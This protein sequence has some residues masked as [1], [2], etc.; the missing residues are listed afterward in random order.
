MTS[1]TVDVAGSDA[2]RVASAAGVHVRN[3]HG[4]AELTEAV[5][6]LCSIW[7]F[8][9]GSVV[10]AELLR[11]VAFAGGYVAAAYADGQVVGASAGF[12]GRHPGDLGWHLHSHISGVV[13]AWQGRH[14]GLA[15]KQHQRAWALAAGVTTIEWTFD[16]LVRRNAFF[17]LVKLGADVVGFEASF[18][19]EM[20]DA[21][22][23]GDESDRAVV[24]WDLTSAAAVSAARGFLDRDQPRG[25]V[26]L[27]PDG[28]GRPVAE[29]TGADVLRA[30][31]PDDAVAL[32]QRDPA[33]GRAW[34]AALRETFGAAVA[35]GYRATS[36]NRDGWYTLVRGS[37]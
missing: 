19:G 2:A 22:N 24:R 25:A 4:M 7:G 3:L 37:G 35:D 5:D 30:W 11:A 32:R 15:L 16:P 17:N 12:L 36:M 9:D 21:I 27:R 18:Y 33:A 6:A 20:T 31:I 28:D 8:T 34:R 10:S 23:A 29:M 14:V 26:I 13:P 1:T